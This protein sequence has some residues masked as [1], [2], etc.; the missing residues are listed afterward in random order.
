MLSVYNFEDPV[1]FLSSYITD[2]QDKDSDFS[3]KSFARDIGLSSPNLIIDILKR[4]KPMKDK[5]AQ[6]LVN[7]LRIDGTERM[8]FEAIVAKK[9]TDIEEKMLMYDLLIEEL[10]PNKEKK[11]MAIYSNEIDIFS[12]WIYTAILA[13]S[14]LP[15]FD[16]SI[17]NIRRKL[18]EE[19]PEEKIEKAICDLFCAGLLTTDKNQVVTAKFSRTTT[20]HGEA[21][22]SANK[23]YSMVCDLAKKSFDLP[24]DERETNSFSFAIDDKNLPLA[25]ELIWK[26]RNGL[27][28][29]SEKGE[30]NRVYQANLMIFPLTD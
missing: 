17:I 20:K 14:E 27:S 1:T 13:I 7:Y 11:F 22:G 12:H 8:Y 10:R 18:K 2:R 29:L 19:F 23:Y 16:F 28:K 6:S 30:P 9:Q 5:V 21:T 4:R 24:I 3:L 15:N 26:C 25:K